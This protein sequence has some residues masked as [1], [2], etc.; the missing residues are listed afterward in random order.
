MPLV[1]WV[2]WCVCAYAYVCRDKQPLWGDLQL[3]LILKS[4]GVKS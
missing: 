4:T 2:D 1:L 3:N